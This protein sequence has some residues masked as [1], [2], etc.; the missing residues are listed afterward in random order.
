MAEVICYVDPDAVG[1]GDGTSWTDAYTSLNAWEAA[2]QTDLPTDG[3]WHHVYWRSSGG[4][5]DTTE[6]EIS[7]WTTAAANYI[8]IEAAD[9]DEALKSGWDATRCRLEVTDP[10]V[11]ALVLVEDYI[12]V[13]GLQIRHIYSSASTKHAIKIGGAITGELQFA[14][15]RIRGDANAASNGNIF[16]ND[17]DGITIKFW[18]CILYDSDNRGIISYGTVSMFNCVIANHSAEGIY[19]RGT[20]DWVIK[21]NVISNTANDIDDNTSG[22]T[23]VQ[24]N[25]ADDDLNTEFGEATNVQPSGG[26]IDNEL[27]DAANG[28][29]TLLSGGNCKNG[30]TNDPGS[31][32]YDADMEGNDYDDVNGWSIGVDEYVA[33]GGAVAPTGALSGPLGGPLAGA[34]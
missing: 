24:Y 23:T 12:R 5:A 11:A 3:D 1:A 17:Y 32:L 25:C 18:N 15:C 2:E 33:A 7:G 13:Y 19:T 27:E 31:G 26:D 6:I 16:Q 21:N 34:F 14:G 30:G 20:H 29:M 22:A 10:N 9:G 4:T 8:L 28:D